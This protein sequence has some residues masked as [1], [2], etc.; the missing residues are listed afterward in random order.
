MNAET[1]KT[2]I[3]AQDMESVHH[4]AGSVWPE[5]EGSHIFLTGGTGFF[6]KWLFSFCKKVAGDLLKCSCNY[7]LTVLNHL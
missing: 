2:R 1:L 3:L 5:L 6:G 4:H 7:E